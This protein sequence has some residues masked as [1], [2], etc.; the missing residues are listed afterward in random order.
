VKDGNGGES[1]EGRAHALCT[2]LKHN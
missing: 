1:R 2:T